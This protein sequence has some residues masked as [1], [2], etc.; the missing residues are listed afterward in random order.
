MTVRPGDRVSIVSPSWAGPEHFPAVYEL[1]L[2]RLREW[3]L[4]PVETPTT[5]HQGSPAERARDLMAA[6]ADPSTTAVL[7]SI[8]GDDQIKVLPHLDPAI[9]LDCP[10]PF[11]GYSDNT[12]LLV[13]LSNLGIPCCHGGSVMVQL[14]RPSRVHPVT[15]ASLQAALFDG[16]AFVV[17]APTDFGDETGDW[18]AFDPA[19]EPLMRP[20][21]PWTWHGPSRRVQ[22]PLWGGNLE[23]LAWTLG[24]GRDVL[25][26][27]A[28]AGRVLLL[29][30][31][32]ELPTADAVY[33]LL[34]VMGERGLLQQ[35]AGLV[36]ARPKAWERDQPRTLAERM[37]YTDDQRAA[38]MRGLQDYAPECVT[39]VGVDCG[40]GD[41]QVVMPI[42]GRC[43]LDP[44]AGTVTVHYS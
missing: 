30:T 5:R 17:P 20:A 6:F 29:E 38:V 18:G 13:W 21:E 15:E 23:I 1:G 7:A 12:N 37:R 44:V 14:G 2:Q 8:G 22:G 36:M 26:V 11:F 10:K 40:H 32:E 28:Y 42:G 3:D 4:E 24:V 33:R 19:A 16:G 35:F 41:P 34:M 9:F 43:D 39:V 27:E 31:S 25:P